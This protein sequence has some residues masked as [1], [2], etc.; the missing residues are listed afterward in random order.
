MNNVVSKVLLIIVILLIAL[1]AYKTIK[2][3][4]T[5]S[6]KISTN[7]INQ[8]SSDQLNEINKTE[9]IIQKYLLNNPEII[10]QA[11]EVLQQR[12]KQEMEIKASQYLKEHQTE[13]NNST[14][15]PALGNSN[16]N[17]VIAAF[18][19]YNCTYCKK[20]D[21]FINQLIKLDPDVKV[22]LK[23]FP[24]LGD[25]SYFAAS[26]ALAVYKTDPTKFKNIHDSLIEMQP[27]TNTAVEK[28]LT[29]NNLNPLTILE[30]ASQEEIKSILEKNTQLARN[31]KIQGV[32]AYI[33]NDRL[34]PGMMDLGQLQKIITEIRS[35]NKQ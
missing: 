29:D 28:L 10:V 1:F 9:Q 14:T 13:V 16:G 26:I 11:M 20:G 30:L 12:K 5:A 19:D 4:S 18:Y 23:P 32:P 34:I 2:V 22:L 24:I 3:P 8:P 25:A 6:A 31:L 7:N 17:I 21:K 27:I 33:I 15:S 35:Q